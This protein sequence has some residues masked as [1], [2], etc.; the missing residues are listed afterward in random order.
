MSTLYIRL[1][2]RA[3]AES[4]PADTAPACLF[5][6]ASD[7]G[8]IEREGSAPV[9]TL[10][11]AVKAAQRVVL[12][13]AASDVALLHVQVPPLSASRL[14]AALP[15]LVEEQLMSDPADCV[16]V[17]GPSNEGLRTVAVV[18]RTWLEK[19]VHELIA[20][21]AR[22]IAA[23][24]AQLCLPLQ[25]DTAAAAISE[26]EATLDIDLALR[27]AAE[28]GIGLSLL[29]EQADGDAQDVLQTLVTLAPQTAL[30]L[31]VPQSRVPVYQMAI[32]EAGLDER[33]R[34]F[35]D[36][37]P[38]WIEGA[39]STSINLAAG[40]GAAGG[41][42]L[43][44]QPWRWPLVLLALVLLVHVVGLNIDWLRM[45]RE[46]SVLRTGMNQIYKA[47][48]PKAPA[49]RDPVLEMRRNI[50]NARRNAGQ[51]APD[52]FL[53]LSSQFGE[54]LQGMGA[55]AIVAGL[56]YADRSLQVK[57]KPDAQPS[58]AQVQAALAARNLALTQK[59]A[60][61]WQIRSAK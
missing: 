30:A 55:S 37:W 40:L 31:Y 41:P 6:L 51:A 21:G 35:A 32:D 54:V 52:D 19:N 16:L 24:P 48:Y 59:S 18:N 17:A 42:G 53:V 27:T 23:V 7:Y 20:L 10:G 46:A 8:A 58:L 56:E 9:N 50:E 14:K 57:L 22:Q 45:K 12:V 25:P 47:V 13:L 28:E 4:A 43:H 49:S 26:F 38:R 15:N 36:N 44:W 1:P 3:A 39:R 61:V 11:E 34:T 60:G 29:P 2:S 5:A 33:I